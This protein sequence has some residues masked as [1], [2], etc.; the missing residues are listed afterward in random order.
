[1]PES[2]VR[3]AVGAHR[4]IYLWAGPGTIRMNRLKFM[5]APVNEAVHEEA[6][7]LRGAVR[8]IQEAKCNW[9]YLMYD[10]GFPPEIEAQDWESFRQ[11]TPVYQSAGA[12][13]FG[14]IQ[15][16]NCVY[17]GSYLKRDWYARDPRGRRYPYYTGRTMTCWQ[18]PE[19]R[20]HLRT[21]VEGV[22]GAGADGVFFDNPWYGMAPL[23]SA[24]T[25]LGGAGC[26]CERC[27]AA[28]RAAA[29][30]EIPRHVAPEDDEASRSYLRW[31]ADQTTAILAELANHARA[32][33]PAIVISANDFDAVMRPSFVAYGID[34]AALARVQDVVM[35]EDYGLVQWQPQTG[36]LAN[37]AITIR[38][39]LS[40]VKGTHL[41]VDPY[42]KG[43]GFDQV[44]TPRR[45]QQ[46]IAEA[47]ACGASMVIKGTEFVEADGTFTLLT[48][49][50]YGA[51]REAIGALHRWLMEMAPLASD[52]ENL[53]P[54]GLLH[55]QDAL[56][57][58]WDRV[59][60]LYFDAGL[61]LLMQRVPWRVVTPEDDLRGL[62]AL[63]HSAPLPQGLNLPE[64][65]Q[66]V[67]LAAL[68]GWE[69]P[70]ASFVA[71]HATFRN[72]YAGIADAVFRAYFDYRWARHLID[73]L[74]LTQKYFI[75]NS[76]VFKIPSGSRQTALLSALGPLPGPR[77]L[78]AEPVL[79]EHWQQGNT[80]QLHLVNYAEAPQEV[81]V[82]FERAVNAE[83][84][85][86]GGQ[87]ATFQGQQFTGEI[88]V[89]L[90]LRIT[91]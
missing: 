2:T 58:R 4:P 22:V 17:S 27:R 49:E 59:A 79:V 19:W 57:Q 90:I 66:V 56:W 55:P 33:N 36:V 52:R 48:A 69:R 29:G 25:W 39:A 15:T 54:V 64:S 28:F 50:K 68:P 85:R 80:Q 13:V 45:Y 86:P 46:S 87:P 23:H 60:P 88:D 51:Q 37:N 65:M 42:D 75:P 53:A 67:S 78:A 71:R 40:L 10:W 84:Y 8:V 47:A 76:T 3:L 82:T 16:S 91:A 81:T 34:L 61:A 24:G 72:L 62:T 12:R 44:Y 9:V 43:I 1:M 11:A 35:I 77:V 41:S 63:L 6:H 30:I 73:R 20:E 18:H 21:M 31:R 26:Y 83:V 7:A 70:A 74:G 38:T 5:N 32:L 89:A 14:Y